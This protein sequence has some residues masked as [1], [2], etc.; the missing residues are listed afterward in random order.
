[1]LA[2]IYS[3]ILDGRVHLVS[4]ALAMVTPARKKKHRG[5]IVPVVN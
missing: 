4:G 3:V 5:V 1:M 2:R